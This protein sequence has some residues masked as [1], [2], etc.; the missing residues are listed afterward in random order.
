[1]D[2]FIDKLAHKISAQEM[3]RANSEADSRQLEEMT[4]QI[5]KY[6]ACMEQTLDQL[7]LQ[8]SRM[9]TIDGEKFAQV[10][11]Q[12][13]D[14]NEQV[15]GIKGQI[16]DIKD[17]MN[18]AKLQADDV[19]GGVNGVRNQLSLLQEKLGQIETAVAELQNRNSVDPEAQK[20]SEE[21]IHRESVKVYRNVQASIREDLQKAVAD[22]SAS[23]Q[24]MVERVASQKANEIM[25]KFT[26]IRVITILTLIASLANIVLVVL[27]MLGIM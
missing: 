16:E 6:D 23:T 17:Q 20:N 26:A 8:I 12:I 3:I 18:G 25:R 11:S 4:E 7:G 9:E 24:E 1:M 10:K 27:K 13:L 21:F 22:L 2:G 19:Q 14:I 15:S 5:K